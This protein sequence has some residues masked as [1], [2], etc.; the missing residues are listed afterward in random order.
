MNDGT[1]E[2]INDV[3]FVCQRQLCAVAK[4]RSYVRV[5]T[6]DYDEMM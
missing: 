4:L 6:A 1:N 2:N 3:L 5:R